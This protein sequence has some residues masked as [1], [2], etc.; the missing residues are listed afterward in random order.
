MSKRTY[1]RLQGL[2]LLV[3]LLVLGSAFYLQY[4]KGLLPCPLC[5]MQRFFAFL[6]AMVCIMGLSLST[7][8]RASIVTLLQMVFSAAGLFFAARQL[9]LQSLPINELPACLP[10]LD[11]LMR[12][13]PWQDVA[14]AL[15]WGTS[16]CGEVNWQFLGLSMPAWAALY[17]LA[18][19]LLSGL[20]LLC[21]KRRSSMPN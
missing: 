1:R 6:F 20:I 9:W 12:Y 15:L 13:F 3:T 19:F 11:I 18:M 8:R 4:M 7:H 17:F 21:L 5:V 14:H 2:L 10:G 16:D